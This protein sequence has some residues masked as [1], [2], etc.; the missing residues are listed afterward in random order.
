MR[1]W[2]AHKIVTYLFAALGLVALNLGSTLNTTLVVVL[3]VG[4]VA[5]WFAED[6][7]IDTPSY[8]RFWNVVAVGAM[9]L[10]FT[11]IVGGEAI[12]TA[13][14][15]YAA[16]LQ[17][18]KLCTRRTANDHQQIIM[19]GFLHLVAATVLSTGLE[20][21][22]VFLGFVVT[23][24]WMLALTHM[25]WEIESYK[26]DAQ[27]AAMQ[28]RRFTGVSFFAGTALLTIPLFIVTATFFFA[29]PRVGLGYL[30]GLGVRTQTQAGFGDNVELG[31]FGTIR[32]DL[33]VSIRVRPKGNT[34][35]RARYLPIRLR[36]TSFDHYD[37]GQWNR[38]THR[39]VSVG[40]DR[41]DYPLFPKL[42]GAPELAYEI[43]VEPMDEPVVFLPEGTVSLQI[44]PQIKAGRE[45]YRTIRYS[46]G[47]DF[48]YRNNDNAPLSYTAHVDS[49]QLAYSENLPSRLVRRYLRVP[50]NYARVA[51]LARQVTEAAQTPEQK[52]QAVMRFLRA[53]GGFKY[54]LDQPD[55][56]G[57][58]PLHVFLFD[59][60]AGHCEYFSTAMAIMLRT[61]GVPTRN[62]TGFLGAD[63]NPFGD[64]YAV[65]NSNAH[66]WVEAL[67]DGK[68]VT[69][70]PTPSGSQIAAPPTGIRV[71][72]QHMLDALRVRWAE[73]VVEYSIRDQGKALG[74]IV[75]R[76]QD[77][78]AERRDAKEKD[79]K[80]GELKLKG[81]G[82]RWAPRVVAGLVGLIVLFS[83]VNWFRKAKHDG[84]Q[85][86]EDQRRAYELYRTLEKQLRASGK[87][88]AP[89]VTPREMLRRLEEDRYD[90]L[91]VVT[92]I[93]DAYLD[94]R[95]GGA[96]LSPERLRALKTK[97]RSLGSKRA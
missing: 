22:V 96:P 72:M 47:L 73:Y 5:S 83:V 23:T 58:D 49:L 86:D 38:S 45:V 15:E 7:V 70:D 31:G 20:Y 18:V 66:S 26:G 8:G 92:E 25:R 30:S 60:K 16:A 56:A 54:T 97:A 17:V 61:V 12:L 29:F 19:L 40:H 65:R 53:D 9:L 55:T 13:G 42:R 87:I 3:V 90:R 14:I 43:V 57:R 41:D 93:T 51:H 71:R 2:L 80:T 27:R 11:R 64:Y 10:Q 81:F 82:A 24:P 77:F 95:F 88:R 37:N 46:V 35:S 63:Y 89:D 69:F 33:T 44:P 84:E 67:I 85:L 94:T 68:W 34:A 28:S 62:V 48:R 91:S 1:F 75:S 52:A 21:G 78:K 32:D 79:Q 74:W 4:F 6:P 50:D 59:A 39:S 36:G 76:Y